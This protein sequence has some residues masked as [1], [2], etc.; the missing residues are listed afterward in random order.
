MKR[1]MYMC[2]LRYLALLVLFF[3]IAGL[4]KINQIG[5]ELGFILCG[6]CVCAAAFYGG[7]ICERIR[8]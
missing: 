3:G 1:T 7:R 8:R 5:D 6:A 4:V 2:F